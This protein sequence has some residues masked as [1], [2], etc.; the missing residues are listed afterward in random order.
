MKWRTSLRKTQQ[1]NSYLHNIPAPKSHLKSIL[2]EITINKWQHEWTT[3]ETGRP[4]FNIIPKVSTNPAPWSREQILFTTGHDPFQNYLKRFKLN[5][6]DLSAY[7]EIG[8]PFHFA[9][10]CDL[11]SSYNFKKPRED[12]TSISCQNLLGNKLSRLNISRLMSFLT[13]HENLIKFQHDR[14]NVTNYDSSS[15]SETVSLPPQQDK[16]DPSRP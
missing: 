9:T 6:S 1:K 13:K 5:N 4:V 11:T 16:Q 3:G 15:N 12:L 8:K 10:S 2:H 14:S 7:G